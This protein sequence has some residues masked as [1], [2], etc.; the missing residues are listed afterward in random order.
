MA[1]ANLAIVG[2]KN[3]SYSGFFNRNHPQIMLRQSSFQQYPL[4][5][6]VF[7]VTC[8]SVQLIHCIADSGRIPVDRES[9]FKHHKR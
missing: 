6:A 2:T 1:G 3:S 5:G 8:A 4:G 9:V 7:R